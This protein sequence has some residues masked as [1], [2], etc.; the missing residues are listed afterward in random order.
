MDYDKYFTATLS[1]LQDERRYRVFADLERIAGRFPC[2]VCHSL[3]ARPEAPRLPIKQIAVNCA[4]LRGRAGSLLQKDHAAL[5]C[6]F[7]LTPCTLHRPIFHLLSDD[8][9][10]SRTT[11]LTTFRPTYADR[12]FWSIGTSGEAFIGRVSPGGALSA[13]LDAYPDWTIPVMIGQFRSWSSPSCPPPT[14]TRRRSK[15]ASH[16]S[17]RTRASFPTWPSK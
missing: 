12:I 8:S 14:A 4:N 6:C 15:C 17:K 2:A 1:R 10:S 16:F 7:T 9:C 11:A 5:S 3:E 13:V